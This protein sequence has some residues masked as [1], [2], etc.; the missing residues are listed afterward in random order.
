MAKLGNSNPEGKGT[1]ALGKA[2]APA[3]AGASPK[4]APSEVTS[5]VP[6]GEPDEVEIDSDALIEASSTSAPPSIP[7]AAEFGEAA[8]PAMSP[9]LPGQVIANRYEVLGVLG[10]GGMGIVYRCRDQANGQF[11]AIKRVTPPEGRLATEYVMWFYKETRALAALDHPNIVRARDFGQLV[12]GSPYLAMD[13]VPGVSLHDLSHTLVGFPII[14]TI[15]DQVL[16]ALA[17]AHARGIIHGDLKPSNVLVEEVAEQPPRIHILDFG[18][19]WLKQDPHDERLDGTKAMEF[20]PHAGAGTPGYMAPEQIQH[21]MHH[22]VGATDLYALGC[23]AYKLLG[24]HAPF[25]G[26]SKELL[27]RHAF[28]TPPPLVPA[29]HVPDGVTDYVMRLL[30]KHPWDRW[31]FA[32]DARQQWA[33]F[34][35]PADLPPA[36]W[37]FPPLGRRAN[38]QAAVSTRKTGRR[39]AN[40]ALAPAPE[41]APGLLSMRPPPLVGRDDIRTR[42]RE[43]CDEVVEGQGAP[44]R[45]VI[46]VGP[47]GVGKS[48]IAEWLCEVV[49]EEGSMVPLRA[50]YRALRTPLDGMV[51]AVTQYLNFERADRDTI[52]RSLLARWKVAPDDKVGRTWV[53]G[54]AEWLRPLGPMSD[55]PL[56]PSG[57][58]FALDTLETR[59]LVIRYTL[60]RLARGRPLLFWLDDLHHASETTLDGLFRI[61]REE[62][63]QRI[64]LVATV[65]S[66]DIQLDTPVAERLRALREAMNGAVLDVQPMDAD[67]TCAL[68]RKS[69]PLDD[70][71]AIEAARRSRGNPLFALQQLHA[72]ALAGNLKLV[73]NL[74]RVPPEVLALRPQTTAELWDSRLAVMPEQHRLAAYAVATLGGDIR[75]EVLQA[76]LTSLGLPGE[77]IVSLQNAEIILPRGPARYGWPHQLLHEHLVGRLMQ[78]DDHR[79]IFRRAA[80]ALKRHP[81]ATT[82]RVVRQRSANLLNAGEPDAAAALLFDYL[83]HSWNGAREPL[84]TLSDLDLLK[85][86]LQGRSLALKHRWQSEALRHVGRTEEARTHAEIARATFEELG[87]RESFA[88][89]LRLLGHLSSERGANVEGLE[90]AKSAREVFVEL[91]HVS[92]QAQ[93]EAVIGEIEYLLGRYDRAREMVAAGEK[94]FAEL[95]QPLGRGQCL[96]LLSWIEHSEGIAERSRRLANEARAEFERAGYR[97]GIAQAETSLAHIEHRLLNFYSAERGARDALTVFET[98]RNPRGQAACERLLAMIGIDTDELEMAELHVERAKALYEDMGDP[99]GV[100]EARLLDCQLALSRGQLDAAGALLASCERMRVEEPEPRQHCRLTQAWFEQLTGNPDR[101]FELL[102]DAADVF[103]ARS[104]CGDHTPHLL[105]RLSRLAWA[106]HAKDRIDAWR[107]V[108]NPRGVRTG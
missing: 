52:E 60:R 41:R 56:G 84:A 22:V 108:L 75:R 55:R 25:N 97:I 38:A 5:P 88:H 33:Q 78:R 42:L 47:A 86:H 16:R 79:Q 72:W 83:N 66:E 107:M 18:L 3:S 49:H 51:G 29:L 48:R 32:E 21:E 106:P 69:L 62:P 63:D 61:H 95:G 91:K 35:P 59:R 71:S 36:T 7:S 93:C 40:P 100:L 6:Q 11:V 76:L 54:A 44:H 31:D 104:R 92:G 102:E 90:L 103:G 89:C 81:L 19:A 94:H 20:A 46:L 37:T 101:A 28:E 4:R 34:R 23:I 8:A 74:Y 58:R 2:N 67:T 65:R 80:D 98:L 30:A 99:W 45:L 9:V 24:G 43:V 39:G 13:L 14:W 68:L 15:V 64:V 73:N 26:D 10:E 77:A 82:R 1:T 85:G 12:D 50:R 53:A 57:I 27:R 70:A 17:H 87:D 105:G 96:L